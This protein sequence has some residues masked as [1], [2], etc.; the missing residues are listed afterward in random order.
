MKTFRSFLLLLTAALACLSCQDNSYTILGTVDGLED[1]DTLILTNDLAAN[2][3]LQKVTVKAGAFELKGMADSVSLHVL[4]VGNRPDVNVS[5]F[6]EPGDIKVHLSTEMGKCSVGGTKA[7]EAWNQL[8]TTTAAFNEQMR[9]QVERLYDQTLGEPERLAIM[10]S[11]Q[12][13]EQQM[14]QMVVETAEKNIDNE[15]GYFVVTH[16]EDDN[17]FSPSRRLALLDQMPAAFQQRAEVKELREMLAS[18]LSTE[19][20]QKMADFELADTEGTAVSAMSII[21]Q[22]ELTIIDFWASWCGPCRQEMPNMVALY[23]DYRD[24][25]LAILGVSLD[26]DK[27][28]WTKAIKQMGMEWPQLSD[29]QGWQSS[30][31]E[32]F[33]VKAIP[34]T[35]IVDREGTIIEKGLRGEQ[36]RQ[37]VSG[38]LGE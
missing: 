24:K 30:A 36:L 32:L 34:H 19:K 22:N 29:L 6:L 16:F 14:V 18:A 26:E 10:D 9:T 25:G 35:V 12:R 2:T 7:N 8:N 1:G 21:G 15:A 38:K 17:L 5:F 4:Y 28:A 31:A 33:Q 27:D 20:G 13:M 3:P 23:K 37:F 11:L